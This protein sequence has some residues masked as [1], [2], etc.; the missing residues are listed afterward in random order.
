[1]IN[2]PAIFFLWTC[3]EWNYEDVERTGSPLYMKPCV[4]QRERPLETKKDRA[5]IVQLKFSK[6]GLAGSPKN[7]VVVSPRSLFAIPNASKM[8]IQLRRCED[9]CRELLPR[10]SRLRHSRH[11]LLA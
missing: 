3:A 6:C 2:R 1:M 5:P 8:G 10:L 11:K 4:R 9:R 7:A